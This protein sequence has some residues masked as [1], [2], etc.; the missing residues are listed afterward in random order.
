MNVTRYDIKGDTVMK[1]HPDGDYVKS[2]DYN[3]IL[4]QRDEL[5]AAAKNVVNAIG[6]SNPKAFD[7]AIEQLKNATE[8]KK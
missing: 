6:Q 3:K 8:E 2:E 5:L 4:T 7:L 1:A